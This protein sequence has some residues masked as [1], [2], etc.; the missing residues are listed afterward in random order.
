[1]FVGFSTECDK[2]SEYIVEDGTKTVL[3]EISISATT[4]SY[5]L[6]CLDFSFTVSKD[7]M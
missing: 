7:D 6:Y 4:L 5:S 2:L 3:W 1:M